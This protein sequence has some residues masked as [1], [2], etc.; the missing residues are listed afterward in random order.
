MYDAHTKIH[1]HS[2]RQRGIQ[3]QKYNRDLSYKNLSEKKKY[4]K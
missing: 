1:Y 3:R 2:G 4:E